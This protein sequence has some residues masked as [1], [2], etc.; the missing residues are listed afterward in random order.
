MSAS[1]TQ[2][3]VVVAGA[4]EARAALAEALDRDHFASLQAVDSARSLD[5]RWHAGSVLVVDLGERP[6]DGEIADWVAAAGSARSS[7]IGVAGSFAEAQHRAN[8]LRLGFVDAQPRSVDAEE[9]RQRVLRI[10]RGLSRESAAEAELAQAAQTQGELGNKLVQAL[11]RLK[12][13]ESKLAENSEIS[14]RA[15]RDRRDLIAYLAHEFRT[16]LNAFLGFSEIM[17]G[18]RFGPMVNE[19]YADY[20]HRMHAA[21]QHM[22][23]L[24]DDILDIS[25]AEAGAL[26]ISVE[27]VEISGVF[28]AVWTMLADQA[29]SAGVKFRIDIMPNFPVLRT[30]PG[31]LRQVVINLVSNAIKFTPSGGGVTLR[32]RVDPRAGALILV[33][34]DTGIGI[35]PDDFI[36]AMQPYTRIPSE[37][38]HRNKGTG[39]GLPLAKALV[40][41]LGGKFELESREG[42]GTVARV[43]FPMTMAKAA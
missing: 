35:R 42:V 7:M 20:A 18:E 31:R 27:D 29:E 24:V 10:A 15:L 38:S 41:R 37:M 4:P 8:A 30:D 43:I 9:L 26:D 6:T 39:L 32:A 23:R 21:S 19:R 17:V 14:R 36:R 1:P 11:K 25:S 22:I 5:R 28:S 33:I 12:T 40:Q 3:R 2:P 16:P 34:R 13:V